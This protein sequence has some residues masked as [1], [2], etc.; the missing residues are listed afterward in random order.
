VPAPK[1]F[2]ADTWPRPTAPTPGNIR[3]VTVTSPPSEVTVTCPKCAHVYQDWRRP[4]VNLDL[5]NF[6]EEYLDRCMSAVCP[7][8]GH[9]V[10]FSAL[11]VEDG[12]FHLPGSAE[13][14]GSDADVAAD[15]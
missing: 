13:E 14:E 11:I 9:K 7:A 6:D 5:D 12:V 10:Y 15:P 3:G 8:C 4:S 2:K 1:L